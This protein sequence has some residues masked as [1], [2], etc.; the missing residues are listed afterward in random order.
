MSHIEASE[1]DQVGEDFLEHRRSQVGAVVERDF[2]DMAQVAVQHVGRVGH[3]VGILEGG[4]LNDKVVER[5]CEQR[6]RCATKVECLELRHA[7]EK[8]QEHVDVQV[9]LDVF[10]GQELDQVGAQAQSRQDGF[11]GEHLD[12]LVHAAGST[13]TDGGEGLEVHELDVVAEVGLFQDVAQEAVEG[14]RAV[15]DGVLVQEAHRQLVEGLQQHRDGFRE[16]LQVGGDGRGALVVVDDLDDLVQDL[17]RQQKERREG[18]GPRGAHHLGIDQ[19]EVL[20]HGGRGKRGRGGLGGHHRQQKQASL[21]FRRLGLVVVVPLRIVVVGVLLVEHGEDV[22]QVAV[23]VGFGPGVGR[24]RRQL[25][26]A[27]WFQHSLAHSVGR[28]VG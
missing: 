21:G 3:G 20:G 17:Q 14:V 28:Y 24:Q 22:G 18:L 15:K 8:K 16:L 9:V 6:Q 13:Q 27:G 23:E 1:V 2:Q 10:G 11:G 19:H 26:A 25:Q 7:V 4:A 5:F 12:L